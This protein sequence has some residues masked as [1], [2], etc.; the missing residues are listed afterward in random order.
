MKPAMA[1][2][3]K[4]GLSEVIRFQEGVAAHAA[5]QD[6]MHQSR[7]AGGDWRTLTKRLASYDAVVKTPLPTAKACAGRRQSSNYTEPASPLLTFP[8][9]DGS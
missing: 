6:S 3:C 9:R 1:L 4:G 7:D 5:L 8:L 2:R